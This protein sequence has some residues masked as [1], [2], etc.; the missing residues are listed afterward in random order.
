MLHVS[1]KDTVS[2]R[3]SAKAKMSARGRPDANTWVF[4]A[5]GREC[6][7]LNLEEALMKLTSHVC[8]QVLHN[9]LSLMC[10]TSGSVVDA[11]FAERTELQLTNAWPTTTYSSK[12][13]EQRQTTTRKTLA[14]N[15]QSDCLSPSVFV[16]N[17]CGALQ[18]SSL[19]SFDSAHHADQNNQSE[20][21]QRCD[22]QQS[23]Y[24]RLRSNAS[25]RLARRT[26]RPSSSAT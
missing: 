20:R 26:N 15:R 14:G 23:T 1:R 11:R 22:I 12:A 4:G 9:L 19:E 8:C 13:P 18:Q 2:F 16:K 5:G 24:Q 25:S 3:P 7:L 10:L 21:S 17:M 6:V